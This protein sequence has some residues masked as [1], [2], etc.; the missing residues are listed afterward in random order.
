[1]PETFVLSLGGLHVRWDRPTGT[2]ARLRLEGELDSLSI[3]VLNQ[4]LDGLYK[5]GAVNITFDLADLGFVDSSG[6][7]ALVGAWRQCQDAGGTA[8]AVN[9]TAMV[10][11]LMDVTGISRYLLDR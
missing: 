4:A 5:A 10:Q 2:D 9:P 1:M 6:L 7:G 11:R 3:P 8:R